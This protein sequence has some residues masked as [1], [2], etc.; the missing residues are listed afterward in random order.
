MFESI[1]QQSHTLQSRLTLLA[2]YVFSVQCQL[3][4]ILHSVA[5][6]N[7]VLSIKGMHTASSQRR[8]PSLPKLPITPS[9]ETSDP[10]IS[11]LMHILVHCPSYASNCKDT[12]AHPLTILSI[13]SSLSQLPLRTRQRTPSSNNRLLD[14]LHQHRRCASFHSLSQALHS[15]FC[16][17][18]IV[19]EP[20]AIGEEGDV[21]GEIERHGYD[22]HRE[23]EEEEGI[24][25][26]C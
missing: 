13:Q 2:R 17:G 15:R 8:L 25:F 5:N 18:T 24:C 16:F 11:N 4:Y 21:L 3:L 22:D 12:A 26:G 23:K 6:K 19:V 7:I 1:P 20:G 10:P 14:L 9:L